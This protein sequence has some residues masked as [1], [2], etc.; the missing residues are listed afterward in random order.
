MCTVETQLTNSSIKLSKSDLV[1]IREDLYKMNY[2]R[3][4]LGLDQS[5]K[6]GMRIW[7]DF[8]RVWDSIILASL[9]PSLINSI[10]SNLYTGSYQTQRKRSYDMII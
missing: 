10:I 5:E 9:N 4:V 7:E 2:L 6:H 1:I 8:Q 3:L